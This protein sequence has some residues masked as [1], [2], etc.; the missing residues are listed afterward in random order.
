MTLHQAAVRHSQGSNMS[1]ELRKPMWD[2]WLC[3]LDCGPTY[4]A[5]QYFTSEYLEKWTDFRTD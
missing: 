4:K 2:G 1:F 3:F 5:I